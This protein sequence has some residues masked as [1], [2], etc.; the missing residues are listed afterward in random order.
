MIGIARSIGFTLIAIILLPA[1]LRAADASP[2]GTSA[3]D[4]ENRML[5]AQVA[6]QNAIIA[7]LR[8]EVTA[9]R[10]IDAPP[11]TR[12]A[13]CV[14]F[15]VECRG[16]MLDQIDHVR[17]EILKAIGNM[18][19]GQ[20]FAIISVSQEK[21][22]GLARTGLPP[23][24]ENIVRAQQFLDGLEARGEGGGIES[25]IRAANVFDPSAVWLMTRPDIANQEDDLR[26]AIAARGPFRYRINTVCVSLDRSG[27]DPGVLF[28]IA[29]STGGICIDGEGKQV[30][31]SQPAEAPPTPSAPAG[32]PPKGPSIFDGK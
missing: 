19:S 6:K 17:A 22:Q 31:P 11:T 15:A 24:S 3:I 13:N 32:P 20:E 9:L 29:V 26:R 5:R 8:S 25:L 23:T 10:G 28:Q 18:K 7:Q 12:P 14:V 4:A 1:G 30:R 2:D 21:V 16:S 27:G